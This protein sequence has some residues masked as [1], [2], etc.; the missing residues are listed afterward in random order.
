MNVGRPLVKY[1]Y[2]LFGVVLFVLP[3]PAYA[4][5]APDG[6]TFHGRIIK[7]DATPLEAPSVDF[8]IQILSPG[9]EACVLYSETHN[10]VNMT[11]SNGMF[12]FIIGKGTPVFNTYALSQVFSNNT[13][14]TGLTCGT[15]T[16]YT[17]ASGDKR[18]IHVK[19]NDG[20][21][22]VTISPDSEVRS[23]P[24]ALYAQQLEGIGKN[25]FVQNT[26]NVS[27]TKV[28]D[29][30][31]KHTELMDLANGAST[32]YVQPGGDLATGVTT[33]ANQVSIGG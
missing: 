10:N 3:V 17:P 4:T 21:N 12:S 25:G 1:F 28:N 33:N 29:L 31:G 18:L 8:T 26:G 15:G 14:M 32:L 16:S 24:Y 5:N 11:G 23:V 9:P 22:I 27:Q 2:V 7:P 19:F 13:T 30:T 6:L 20:T